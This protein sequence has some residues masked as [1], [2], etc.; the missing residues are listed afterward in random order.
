SPF[1]HI[2]DIFLNPYKKDLIKILKD[3]SSSDILDMGVGQ[4]QYI[5]HLQHHRFIGIDNAEKMLNKAQSLHIPHLKLYLMDAHHLEFKDNTFDIVIMNHVLSVVKHPES[6][7]MEA[8][9][10]LKP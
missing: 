2:I 6:V 5:Q 10:V 4:A 3:L 1:Y 8:H 9:R 7:L